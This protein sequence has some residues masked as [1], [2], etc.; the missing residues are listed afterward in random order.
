MYG[1]GKLL[2]YYPVYRPRYYIIL[3]GCLKFQN[4]LII[5]LGEANICYMYV[6]HCWSLKSRRDFWT[7][8][9]IYNWRKTS[10]QSL[11]KIF[12]LR[13]LFEILDVWAYI[14][15]LNIHNISLLKII[16]CVLKLKDD[17][18]SISLSNLHSKFDWCKCLDRSDLVFYF[19]MLSW[20]V[21]LS[22][23][24]TITGCSQ[25]EWRSLQYVWCFSHKFIW[26]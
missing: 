8:T 24:C 13:D 9:S 26:C 11:E 14:S 21:K 23:L 5:K 10:S 6:N 3:L 7:S 19:K 4:A 20:V 15:T 22:H 16:F 1:N 18:K 17:S 25:K 12:P 2:Q